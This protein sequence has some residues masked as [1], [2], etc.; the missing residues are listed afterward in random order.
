[1]IARAVVCGNSRDLTRKDKIRYLDGGGMLLVQRSVIYPLHNH[2]ILGKAHSIIPG[3]ECAFL[4]LTSVHRRGQKRAPIAGHCSD[5]T[6]RERGSY[7]VLHIRENQ[8]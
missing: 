3:T 5:V 4:Y 7:A 6:R 1:M 2:Y 8:K